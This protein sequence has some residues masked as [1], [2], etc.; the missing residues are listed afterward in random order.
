MPGTWFGQPMGLGS[1]LF[2][3]I[4]HLASVSLHGLDFDG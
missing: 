1:L 3:G 4:I 2:D